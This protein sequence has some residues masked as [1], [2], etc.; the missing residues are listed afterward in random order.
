MLEPYRWWL[1]VVVNSL[2][3]DADPPSALLVPHIP[4]FYQPLERDQCLIAGLAS[5]LHYC[6]LSSQGMS[7]H[8]MPRRFEYLPKEFALI[9]LRKDMRRKLPCIGECVMFNAKTS[10][11]KSIKR[12]LSIQD[13]LE[14]RTR[15]P[16]VVIPFGRD[17]SNN[18]SFVVVDDLIFDSTQPCATNC[19]GT[20][21]T[22]SAETMEWV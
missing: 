4:V 12:K 5:S 19:V 18:H 21:S 7:L 22:G 14:K 17:G 15:F 20:V 11:K 10:K 6:G 1:M 2:A 13:L 9:E 3:H 16:M 8:L